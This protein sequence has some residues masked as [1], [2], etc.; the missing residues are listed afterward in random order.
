MKKHVF[1]ALAVLSAVLFLSITVLELN[2]HARAGGGRS[3][4]SSGSRS[5]SRP[6]SPSSQPY[7]SRQ[8]SPAPSPFQQPMGGGGFMR[9]MAG[10]LV[11]GMLGGMLFRSLGFG[12]SGGMGGGGIGLFEI[13]LLAGIGYLI[14]R[15][16]KKKRSENPVAFNGQGGY[17]GGTVTQ[18]SNYQNAEL[19]GGDVDSGLAHIRQ[20]DPS[21]DENRFNDTVMDIFFK[22][23]G[24]WMNRDLAP[25]AGLLTDE[26]KRIFQE[27]LDRLLRDKQ[28]NRLENIAVRNVEI[29]EAWQESGQDYITAAIYANLLD[30]TTDDT[31][32][33]VVA[34]SK[35]EPVKFEEYWTFTRPVGNNPWRLTAINQK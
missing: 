25:V 4:G 17:Q 14:Y 21:F 30:Y 15:Y 28:I 5:Y 1:Q 10:G 35:T 16:I 18:L 23:Q 34:G 19:T 26:I 32:G 6:A 13:L 29:S 2:A 9:S 12:G 8:A 22:I 27:D 24:S 31:S 20:M 3:F 11:G 7:Q 33:A